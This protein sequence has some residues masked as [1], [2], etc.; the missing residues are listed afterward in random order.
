MREANGREPNVR[1][2]L[3]PGATQRPFSHPKSEPHPSTTKPEKQTRGVGCPYY[4]QVKPKSSTLTIEDFKCI[5]C[6]KL[7]QMPADQSRGIILCPNCRHPA[8]ADEFRNWTQSSN[9]CSRC[10]HKL[11]SNFRQHPK[12]IEMKEYFE[13]IREFYRR[14]KK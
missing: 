6:F 8:H 1:V 7:P 5:F 3:P 9:L 12:I 13:I 14:A 2:I 10:G 11:P 4:D